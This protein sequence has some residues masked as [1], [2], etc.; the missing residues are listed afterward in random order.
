MDEPEIYLGSE[1][2][3]IY[4]EKDKCCAIYQI[5]IELLL[6]LTVRRLWKKGFETSFERY[7]TIVHN[8]YKPEL[9]YTGKLKT[10]GLQ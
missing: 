3:K 10:I 4:N 8:G 7:H 9:D 5:N 6:S 1:K 2:S